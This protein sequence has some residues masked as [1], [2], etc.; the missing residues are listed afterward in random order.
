MSSDNNVLVG[1]EEI[2]HFFRVSR[3]WLKQRRDQMI[4]AGAIHKRHRPRGGHQYW[5]FET[6]LKAWAK[7]G[8]MSV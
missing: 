5:G 7:N 4:T 6:D 2:A 1:W 8:G 3:T